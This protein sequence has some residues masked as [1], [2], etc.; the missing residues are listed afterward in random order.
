V[1]RGKDET[2]VSVTLCQVE[3]D[4]TVEGLEPALTRH[5]YPGV[6]AETIDSVMKRVDV[7]NG[8]IY[9]AFFYCQA[10][11]KVKDLVPYAEAI[12]EA[13]PTQWIFIQK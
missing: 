9:V 1:A 10:D 7:N 4:W 8:R 3:E 11:I 12:K 5:C 2:P 13:C 6:T